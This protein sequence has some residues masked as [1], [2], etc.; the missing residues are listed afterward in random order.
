MGTRKLNDGEVTIL[1]RDEFSPKKTYLTPAVQA[2][3]K[4]QVRKTWERVSGS[5]SL[6][7]NA[8]AAAWGV[9]SGGASKLLN[10]EKGHPLTPTYLKQAAAFMRVSPA[11]E[12]LPDEERDELRSLFDGFV[13][14]EPDGAF[15]EECTDAIKNHFAKLGIPVKTSRVYTL[16]GKLCEKLEGSSPSHEDMTREI[17]L[18]INREAA[19]A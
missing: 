12:F 6:T 2:R 8:L 5:R 18:L 7:Q 19:H 9:S 3:I 15:L 4:E 17:T 13:I 1:K 16:A 14:A 10:D 11:D